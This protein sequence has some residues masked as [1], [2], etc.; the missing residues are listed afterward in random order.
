MGFVDIQESQSYLRA[1]IT[2]SQAYVSNFDSTLMRRILG[3]SKPIEAIDWKLFT[4]RRDLEIV[5][6][7]LFDSLM[8]E[9][10]ALQKLAL[11]D[12]QK[13][14]DQFGWPGYSLVGLEASSAAKEIAIKGDSSYLKYCLPMF[15]KSVN[16]YNGNRRDLAY[17]EDRL[18]FLRELPLKYGIHYSSGKENKTM[19]M[20]PVDDW[21]KINRRRILAGMEIIWWRD[22]YETF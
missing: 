13:I 3:L 12:F 7:L 20:N 11:A 10:V 2:Q 4:L 9:K 14:I 21:V 18:L 1:F 22:G 6:G 17:M 15:R 5:S 8:Q 19:K 16:N